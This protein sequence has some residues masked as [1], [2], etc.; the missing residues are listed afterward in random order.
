MNI[1]DPLD[2]SARL[3]ELR[4]LKDG[5]L[6]GQGVALP[7]EGLNWLSQAFDQHY[8]EDLPLPCLYP[9]EDGGIEAEWSLGYN[10][11]TLEIDLGAG[12]GYWHSLNM[13]TN[14][15][16]EQTL[17]LKDEKFWKWLTSEIQGMNNGE[18]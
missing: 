4:L 14:A 7:D 17:D 6:D 11:V 16:D 13:K 5:W 8:P 18:G 3:R 1:H 9:T 12:S 10:E 2:I 15:E